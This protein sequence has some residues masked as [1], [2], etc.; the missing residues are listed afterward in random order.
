MGQSTS[1]NSAKEEVPEEYDVDYDYGESG[2]AVVNEAATFAVLEI[3]YELP[4]GQ[5]EK[6]KLPVTTS[7]KAKFVKRE[8]EAK[9]DIEPYACQLYLYNG[10]EEMPDHCTLHELGIQG[11]MT[12]KIRNKSLKYN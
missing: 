8:L 4:N 7:K 1:T 6:K 11:D 2:C 10:K 9:F 3:I 12:L 5:C